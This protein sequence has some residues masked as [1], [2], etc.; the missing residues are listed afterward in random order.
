MH[1]VLREH[2]I[3]GNVLGLI[4]QALAGS[5]SLHQRNVLHHGDGALVYFTFAKVDEALPANEVALEFYH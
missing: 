3:E 4:V 1:D 2:V 5:A